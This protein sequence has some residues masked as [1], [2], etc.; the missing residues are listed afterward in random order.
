MQFVNFINFNL[1]RFT[2]KSKK[3]KLGFNNLYIFP[4]L[5]GFFWIFISLLLYVLGVNLEADFT[6][7]ISYLM[8]VVLAINLFLSHFNLHGL[9]LYASKQKVYFAKSTIYYKVKIKSYINR[10]NIIIK[11][12]DSNEDHIYIN[13][14]SREVIEKDLKVE[15][16]QRGV[17]KP[18]IIYGVS[19][20]PMSLF[21][22]WFYW[23]PIE[24]IVVAPQAKKGNINKALFNKKKGF[25]SKNL[26]SS[27]NN[28]K[29]EINDFKKYTIEENKA[30]IYWKSFAKNNQLLLKDFKG[31]NEDTIWLELNKRIPLEEALQILT[32]SVKEENRKGNIFGIRE[33]NSIKIS[34]NKGR[35]H[36]QNCLKFLAYY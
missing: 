34:P 9:E 28:I 18:K 33:N 15:G 1:K 3:I 23:D 7:L 24:V 5:F 19:S 8:I 20:A 14:I 11:F 12:A 22:C 27:K 17:Y 13:S 16:K 36:Y 32:Y 21:N 30:Y 31:G 29:E 4:N 2:I 26:F 25:H 6:I 10:N 35:I